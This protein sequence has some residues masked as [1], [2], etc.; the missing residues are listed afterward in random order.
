MQRDLQITRLGGITRSVSLGELLQ[1]LN[2]TFIDGTS[3]SSPNRSVITLNEFSEYLKTFT[4]FRVA[5]AGVRPLAR[6][7]PATRERATQP[8]SLP[9]LDPGA[10]WG[11]A[12]CPSHPLVGR[13][14][15]SR[16]GVSRGTRTSGR[17]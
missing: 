1:L 8:K 9:R 4:C 3:G 15:G 11:R 10:D 6:N 7:V 14:A 12:Y 2:V 17:H 13:I 5:F 16:S